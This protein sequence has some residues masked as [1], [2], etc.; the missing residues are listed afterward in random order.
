GAT[1]RPAGG[2]GAPGAASLPGAS[3]GAPAVAPPPAASVGGPAA[4]PKMGQLL[5]TA[6]VAGAKISIDVASEPGWVTPY[7]S[8][9]SRPA[10][11]HQVVISKEGHRDYMQSVTIEGGKTATINAQ[12]SEAK[13][14]LLVT[15]TPPGLEVLIDGKSIGPSPVRLEVAAG[16]HKYTVK[17]QGW[18]PYEGTVNV[19][20]GTQVTVKVNMGG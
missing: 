11:T 14:E 17:R 18:D 5:I 2:G 1:S 16:S 9:I 10:G 13:G 20:N 15:T 6:D 8:A 19:G 4:A 12:L 7:S 3:G